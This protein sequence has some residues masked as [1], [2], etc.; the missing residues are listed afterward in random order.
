MNETVPGWKEEGSALVKE[1]VFQDFAEAFGF[2]ASV[3]TAAE[4]LDHHPDWSNSYNRVTIRLSTHSEGT[5][6]DLDIQLAK[7]CNKLAKAA[8]K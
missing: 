2:M 5:I 7:R 4:K 6:T 3:A 8:Q 1:F